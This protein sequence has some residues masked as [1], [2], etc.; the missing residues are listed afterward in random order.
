[1][2]I[3]LLALLVIPVPFLR[4]MGLGGMLIPLVSTIVVLTLLPAMLGGIGPRVDW[5][6]IRHENK[7]SRGW[8]RWAAL[9]VRRRWI[10]AAAAL[11]MLGGAHR[12]RSSA[13]RSGWRRPTRWPAEGRPT[14]PCRR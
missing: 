7:V 3:S 6:K 13:S 12:R 11:V 14:R 1:M 4:S 2:A 10:A 8:T 5:P 9:V